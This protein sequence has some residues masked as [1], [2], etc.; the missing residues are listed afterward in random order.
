MKKIKNTLKVIMIMALVG[1]SFNAFSQIDNFR[2]WDQDGV[3]VFEPKKDANTTFDGVKVKVGGAFTQQFQSLSHENDTAG[4]GVALYDL[5]PGFPLATANLNLDVQ[6]ADGIRMSLENYMSSRH[7]TEFWVKGG[8]IQID[9]LPML[10]NP[11]FF[12]DKMRVKIGHYQPNFGDQ[13][14]RRSDNGNA[15]YNQ[16]VGNYIMD[17]FTT[18]V[19]GEVYFFATEDIMAMVGLTNGL[20]NGGVTAPADPNGKERKPTL[21]LKAAYDKEINDDTRVRLSASFMNNA[22]SGRNTF[23]GGDRTGSRFYGAMEESGANLGGSGNFA[24]GRWNP[25]F[26]NQ[27]QAIQINPFVKFKGLEIFGVVEMANGNNLVVD[28]NDATQFI[29]DDDDKRSVM[30]VGGELLYRFLE[31]ESAYVGFKYNSLSGQLQGARDMNGDFYESSISRI[32]AAAGWYATKN[33]LLK[34]GY[35][36]QT[37]TDFQAASQY[38]G[39]SFNGVVIE[40]VAAF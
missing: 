3:N 37:Y 16:F 5:A 19:G 17:G 25:R 24:S 2:S 32:E 18:E 1:L 7:H 13:Q 15:M 33:L 22:N 23:Y 21:Y 12:T 27:I 9:K 36:N 30:Q 8:Y 39:G 31:N 11:E 6:L 40:A 29:F 20:I 14:F 38:Q 4:N 28:P 26:G 34:A 10:G 35:V